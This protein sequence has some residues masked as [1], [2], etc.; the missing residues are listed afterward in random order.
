MDG[1]IGVSECMFAGCDYPT[2]AQGLC[3]S[4][5]RQQRKGQRLQPVKRQAVTE[6]GRFWQKVNK[7]GPIPERCPELGPCWVWAS[8]DPES[9]YGRFW[10]TWRSE[11]KYTLAH[12]YSFELHGGV[13]PDGMV[14]DHLCRNR[15]CVNYGHLEPV[16]PTENTYR[17]EGLAPTNIAKT[18]CP[19]GHE[20]D[21]LNT[22]ISPSTGSRNCRIC[23]ADAQRRYRANK[24]ARLAYAA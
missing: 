3:E 16:T 5:Y 20:Y 17:G 2:I 24:K 22:Y 21:L 11:P 14:I 8:P 7:S 1:G 18:H 4:H 6:L 19:G 12:R 9:G 15:S 13:I 10:G 23:L